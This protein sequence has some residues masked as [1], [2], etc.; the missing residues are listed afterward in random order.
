MFFLLSLSTDRQSGTRPDLVPS[1]FRSTAHVQT[2]GMV[3]LLLTLSTGWLLLH[4]R[5]GTFLWLLPGTPNPFF[6]LSYLFI[7]YE[8]IAHASHR[9]TG[10]KSKSSSPP[11]QSIPDAS[12]PLTA[13]LSSCSLCPCLRR[14]ALV[15]AA[16]PKARNVVI[17]KSRRGLFSK[18][19]SHGHGLRGS[20]RGILHLEARSLRE[21]HRS[22]RAWVGRSLLRS[23]HDREVRRDHH[24]GRPGSCLEGWSSWG[25]PVITFVSHVPLC[26]LS[27]RAKRT[28]RFLFLNTLS[29]STSAC[30]TKLGSENST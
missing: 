13:S 30:V 7:S 8:L 22:L 15:R 2:A 16:T 9:I 14:V 28:F 24:H 4:H 11:A 6:F 5:F 23:H 12:R 21:G 20:R 26:H 1:L 10:P 3:I 19:C 17:V 18:G 29:L 27:H 25:R